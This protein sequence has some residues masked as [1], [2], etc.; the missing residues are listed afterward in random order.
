MTNIRET[1]KNLLEDTLPVEDKQRGNEFIDSVK[2]ERIRILFKAFL[3]SENISDQ[4]RDSCLTRGF[5]PYTDQIFQQL[6]TKIIQFQDDFYDSYANNEPIGLVK[7]SLEYLQTSGQGIDYIEG[8]ELKD[9]TGEKSTITG[10]DTKTTS[11]I[12]NFFSTNKSLKIYRK[13]DEDLRKDLSDFAIACNIIQWK[14]LDDLFRKGLSAVSG[15]MKPD[16]S[17]L[18]SKKF[19]SLESL[20]KNVIDRFLISDTPTANYIKNLWGTEIPKAGSGYRE[21]SGVAGGSADI[22][23]AS[24]LDVFIEQALIWYLSVSLLNETKNQ[25]IAKVFSGAI[26]NAQQASIYHKLSRKTTSLTAPDADSDESTGIVGAAS[27]AA[28]SVEGNDENQN[29]V[30]YREELEKRHYWNDLTT[31]STI[32]GVDNISGTLGLV[33]SKFFSKVPNSQ[34]YFY[35]PS[36]S[37]YTIASGDIVPDNIFR[38]LKNIAINSDNVVSEIA[39][40]LD[41]LGETPGITTININKLMKNLPKT[42]EEGKVSY[43]ISPSTTGST[44]VKN[45]TNKSALQINNW[46]IKLSKLSTEFSNVSPSLTTPI[47]TAN[48]QQDSFLSKQFEMVLSQ[49]TE[50]S[51]KQNVL[52]LSTGG[53]KIAPV[54]KPEDVNAKN[55]LNLLYNEYIKTIQE[56]L[57]PSNTDGWG[58]K[59]P[60]VLAPKAIAGA[61]K[62]VAFPTQDES[63]KDTTPISRQGKKLALYDSEQD[64]YNDAK[65]LLQILSSE[66]TKNKFFSAKSPQDFTNILTNI[67]STI[68]PDKQ[69]VV[70]FSSPGTVSGNIYAKNSKLAD[71]IDPRIANPV[72]PRTINPFTDFAKNVLTY[73][74]TITDSIIYNYIS[75]LLEASEV[76]VSYTNQVNYAVV[77]MHLRAQILLVLANFFDVIESLL[78]LISDILLPLPKLTLEKLKL[79]VSDP[80]S[81]ET[82]EL[83]NK[84]SDVLIDMITNPAASKMT[85]EE[86]TQQSI[87]DI[88]KESD[89]LVDKYSNVNKKLDSSSLSNLFGEGD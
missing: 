53:S 11:S 79:S 74:N 52:G 42:S 36:F 65:K 20:P 76:S 84:L 35:G 64:F 60:T 32:F 55:K 1:L 88:Y 23:E 77:N 21:D 6:V 71:L 16:P 80:D 63:G 9:T 66:D 38:K 75:Q 10:S 18:N 4:F 8:E 27:R 46:F 59:I 28:E 51:K 31:L 12:E 70:F 62:Y 45:I 68:S 39:N 83:C 49:D 82:Q 78:K 56:I 48:L 89:E 30:L 34:K 17:Y 24:F 40:I 87:I 47:S 61:S 41:F 7:T 26:K 15:T 73:N 33:L 19:K 5:D 85:A 22:G 81:S 44:I 29:D 2:A 43:L 3:K 25:N 50:Q 57:S 14:A 86:A 58:L 67:M 69:K 54:V 72:A 13:T 37:Y